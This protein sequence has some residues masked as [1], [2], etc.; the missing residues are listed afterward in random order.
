MKTFTSMIPRPSVV[1]LNNHDKN[2]QAPGNLGPGGS[3]WGPWG[4]LSCG[5]ATTIGLFFFIL[6]AVLAVVFNCVA[7]V[8]SK[9]V[10][11]TFEMS[12]ASIV[13]MAIIGL[14]AAALAPHMGMVLGIIAFVWVFNL[15]KKGKS[16]GED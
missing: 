15:I 14:V 1:R 6:W 7:I 16:F 10:T 13:C 2:G 4:P 8:K 12:K 11:S 9:E 3:Q 5:S